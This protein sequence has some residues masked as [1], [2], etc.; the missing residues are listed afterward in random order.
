MLLR[1]RVY[2][3]YSISDIES[4]L[5][6]MLVNLPQRETSYLFLS[7]SPPRAH[8]SV[9]N[10]HNVIRCAKMRNSVGQNCFSVTEKKPVQ[11]YIHHTNR[12]FL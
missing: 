4:D 11:Y 10:K 7:N 1:N 2:Q 3:E 8:I 5:E 12:R 6:D 9:S